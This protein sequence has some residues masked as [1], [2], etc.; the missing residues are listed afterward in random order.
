MYLVDTNIWL[1]HLLNQSKAREASQFITGVDTS[2]L[3]LSDFSFHSICV[4]LG[5]ANRTAALDQFVRDLFI[6]GQVSLRTIPAADTQTITAAM[7]AQRLDFDDAYQYVLSR[8]DS[9]TLISFDTHF[10]R[11]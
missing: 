6:N 9:L 7:Q 10:D 8:R 5:R 3:F 11:T 4:I 2:Q 1:E